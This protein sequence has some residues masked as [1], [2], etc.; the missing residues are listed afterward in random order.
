MKLV[1][2]GAL[3]KKKRDSCMEMAHCA[4]FLPICLTSVATRLG[5]R[6][7]VGHFG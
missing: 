2:Y 4:I 1:R 5:D 3:E 7:T 6:A